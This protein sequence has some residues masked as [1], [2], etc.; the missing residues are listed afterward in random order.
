MHPKEYLCP[1][2]IN[3]PQDDGYFSCLLKINEP[4]SAG[5]GGHFGEFKVEDSCCQLAHCPPHEDLCFI[6]PAKGLCI[7]THQLQNCPHVT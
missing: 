2:N 1:L 6:Q 7:N 4:S 5:L 3:T